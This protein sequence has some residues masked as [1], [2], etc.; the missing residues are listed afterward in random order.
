MFSF[1][2][3]LASLSLYREHVAERCV[4]SGHVMGLSPTRRRGETQEGP[5][6]G[7]SGA[8]S[9]RA[10]GRVVLLRI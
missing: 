1:S 5:D 8:V 3:P 9:F 10:P 4:K 2:L 7:S 6:D